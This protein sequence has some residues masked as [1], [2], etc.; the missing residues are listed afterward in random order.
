MRKGLL[1]AI[2][3]LSAALAS[4]APASAGTI[5]LPIVASGTGQDLGGGNTT[6]EITTHGILLGT[7]TGTFTVTGVVGTT[8]S[9]VGPIVFTTRVGT[10]TAQVR[11]TLDTATGA[12]RSDSTSLT[13]TGL[14][15]GVTGN[16]RLVG[17]ENLVTGAFTETITGRLCAGFPH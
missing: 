11:G 1:L 10:L 8:A 17:T 2:V 15:K 16:V 5:C 6:A 13:G 7:T 14:F 3:T 4:A 12:F 9:F